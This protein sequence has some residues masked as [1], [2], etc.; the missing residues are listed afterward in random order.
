MYRIIHSND[1]LALLECD[2]ED[3]ADSKIVDRHNSTI[4][5]TC[6]LHLYT[7]VL[8]PPLIKLQMEAIQDGSSIYQVVFLFSACLLA[9]GILLNGRAHCMVGSR[10]FH[11]F[12][13]STPRIRG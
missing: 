11:T 8:Y 9:C 6:C 5:Y 7:R 2:W 3:S 1:R 12:L 10:R 13:L 4:R